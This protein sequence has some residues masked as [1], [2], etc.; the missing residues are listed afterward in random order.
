MRKLKELIAWGGVPTNIA[1]DQV[2]ITPT[3]PEFIDF[4]KQSYLQ[5]WGLSGVTVDLEIGTAIFAPNRDV[6]IRNDR[7]FRQIEE[8]QA[9]ATCIVKQSQ[10]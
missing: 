6:D 7:C 5:G 8:N 2:A 4:F 10:I 9:F 1:D 3:D